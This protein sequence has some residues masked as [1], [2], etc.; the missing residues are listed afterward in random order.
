VVFRS[1]ERTAGVF[2]AELLV[3]PDVPHRVRLVVAGFNELDRS[4]YVGHAF[5]RG[6]VGIAGA[7]DWKGSP[8]GFFARRQ[9]ATC[10][11][12]EQQTAL[13]RAVF[14]GR[15]DLWCDGRHAA[16]DLSELQGDDGLAGVLLDGG[17][18]LPV[19][20]VVGPL[21]PHQA[22]LTVHGTGRPTAPVLTVWLSTRPRTALAGWLDWGPTRLGCYLTR[23]SW[24]G[25]PS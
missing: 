6:A 7:S 15:W 5:T 20:A 23:C 22:Q 21:V 14:L 9:T 3:D 8:F 11:G 13:T 16:L 24:A 18:A 25:R 2:A 10:P 12:P 4:V 1:D 17:D 19:T